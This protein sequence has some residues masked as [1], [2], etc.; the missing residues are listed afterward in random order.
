VAAGLRAANGLCVGPGD[1]ITVA[2]NPRKWVPSSRI[3]VIKRGGFYGWMPHVLAAGGSPR[4]DYDAPLCWIPTTVDNS[5]GS[6]VW[7]DEKRFGPGTS[8]M[9]HTSYGR[10]T[11]RPGRIQNLEDGAFNGVVFPLPFRFDS[12]V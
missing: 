11:L 6:Q 1:F 5:S 2:D 9:L 3:N 7:A 4:T 10:G 8:L 12:G